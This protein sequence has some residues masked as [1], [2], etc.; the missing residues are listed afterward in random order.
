MIDVWIIYNIMIEAVYLIFFWI[1]VVEV[2]VFCFLSITPVKW[3]GK[4]VKVLTT[5][6]IV[7]TLMKA[8]LGCCLLAALFYYDCY[9]TET[10]F[11]EEKHRLKHEG[12]GHM[13]S[14]TC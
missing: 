2:V 4:V 9:S 7:K 14:G 10:R 3:K 11:Q 12:H 1:L 6:S 13:G 5:S 8:H